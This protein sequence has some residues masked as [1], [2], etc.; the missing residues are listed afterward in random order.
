MKLFIM[1][2]LEISDSHLKMIES[3]DLV[4]IKFGLGSPVICFGLVQYPRF[5]ITG[6][7]LFIKLVEC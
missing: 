3:R 5:S 2:L 7:E 4:A 1:T 6:S